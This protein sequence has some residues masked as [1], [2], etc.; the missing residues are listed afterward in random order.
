MHVVPFQNVCTADVAVRVRYFLFK[1]L[2]AWMH[3]IK[4]KW[5]CFSCTKISSRV[6]L[7]E[8]KCDNFS[9]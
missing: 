8:T 3:Y 9:L 4:L 1:Q 6:F 2:R 5:P 7:N